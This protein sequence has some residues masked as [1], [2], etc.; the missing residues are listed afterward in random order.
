MLGHL[1][2]WY[3][4]LLLQIEYWKEGAGHSRA[5]ARQGWGTELMGSHQATPPGSWV[6][7]QPLVCRALNFPLRMCWGEWG[8]GRKGQVALSKLLPSMSQH[9]QVPDG[10]RLKPLFAQAEASLLSCFVYLH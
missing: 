5:H 2:G 9:F 6:G 8:E 7:S 4:T 1:Q 3:H 10:L